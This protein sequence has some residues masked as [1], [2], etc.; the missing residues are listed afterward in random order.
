[1]VTETG[2]DALSHWTAPVFGSVPFF[3]SGTEAIC[4]EPLKKFASTHRSDAGSRT[5]SGM[6]LFSAPTPSRLTL[7]CAL[8]VGLKPKNGK[9]RPRFDCVTRTSVIAPV[10]LSSSVE[11]Q[12]ARLLG[13]EGSVLLASLLSML[14]SV[15]PLF[16]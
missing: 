11:L 16:Q 9:K 7:A 2:A 13:G 10:L 8:I 5:A 4:V 1:M 15:P 3:D 14:Q 12:S 6:M